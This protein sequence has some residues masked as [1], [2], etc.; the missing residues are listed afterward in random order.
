MLRGFRWQ[1]LALVVALALF[2]MSLI[3]RLSVSPTPPI[4]EA[5]PRLSASA[6]PTLEPTPLSATPE[7]TIDHISSSTFKEALVGRIQRLNPLYSPLNPVD[8]DISAL[9]FEGLMQLDEYGAPVPLLAKDWIISNDGLEYIIILREDILWQDGIPFNADDVVYTFSILQSPDYSGVESLGAFWQTVEVEKLDDFT[10]RFRLAQ[11]LGNFLTMLTIGILPYHALAGTNAQLLANHPFNLAPIGTGPYQLEAIRSTNGFD[12]DIIDLQLSPVYQ[13]RPENDDQYNISRIRFHLYDNFSSA[14]QSLANG[15]IDALAA[16]TP[17][18]REQLLNLPD[19]T[20][21]NG[22]EPVLGVLIFNWDEGENRFFQDQRTRLALLSALDRVTPIETYL[23]N[24]AIPANSPVILGSWAYRP[25]LPWPNNDLALA[26]QFLSRANIILESTPEPS[27]NNNLTNSIYAFTILTPNDPS[28]ID[29]A[30]DLALQ[31]SAL[32][33]SVSVEAVDSLIYQAR[34]ESGD[35]DTALVELSMGA[36][37]DV[38]AYWHASQHPDGKNY[39]GVSD[40]RINE[41]LERAR[42]D[43]YGINRVQLYGLFQEEFAERAIAIP[44]YYPLYTYAVRNYVDGVQLGF[45][46]SP[47]DRFRTIRAWQITSPN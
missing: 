33:L 38:Y 30:N 6:T 1:F 21:Y 8:Y 25:S 13:Q 9:I 20:I 47:I 41:L 28:L 4:V 7:L 34:L 5:P 43:A 16:R 23:S 46:S 2:F 22:L 35:F 42:R 10:V 40:D 15:S 27:N 18:E 24:R 44:L 12:V 37:P 36:D 45:I 11:P 32:N 26:Q 3:S 19:V 39:G 17:I 14:V 29:L 31:W